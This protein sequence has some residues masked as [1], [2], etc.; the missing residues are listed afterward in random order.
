MR[1]H[2][3]G[4]A[5]VA[6]LVVLAACVHGKQHTV[7]PSSDVI[8]REQIESTHYLN[9]YDVV[10]ALH[11]NWLNSKSMTM[12]G[13]NPDVVVYYDS[14]RLGRIEDLRT[15]PVN[16]IEYIQH[17]DGVAATTRFGVGHPNG[18]I[19]VS[20]VPPGSRGETAKH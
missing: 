13:A 20:S 7:R 3:G 11:S 1:S 4:I 9:A 16:A 18:V 15:I 17:Y 14:N 12:M 2:V 19:L 6:L 10:E 8:T 5:S